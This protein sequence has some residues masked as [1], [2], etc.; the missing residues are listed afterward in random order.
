PTIMFLGFKLVEAFGIR[1]ILARAV[2]AG[3]FT[4]LVDA[5]Y[6]L[7]GPLPGVRWWEWLDWTIG[8]RHMFRYWYGWPM[9]EAIWQMTWPPL[10]MWL[11]W[12]WE[13]RRAATPADIAA[14]R[15]APWV[16]LLGVPVLIGLLVNTGGMLLSFPIGIA[17]GL[18]LPHYPFVLAVAVLVCVVFLFAD[19]RPVGLD[20]AGWTLLGIHVVGYGIITAANFAA[21]PVPAGQI[22]IVTLALTALVVL[23]CYARYAARRVPDDA[24]AESR[25]SSRV[26]R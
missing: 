21:R 24:R 16:T 12:Q 1:S 7:T 5:P 8:G 15:R 17:I 11:V 26:V 6:G 22:V 20:R 3:V 25:P 10:L 23:A 18:D 19:K 2:S 13:R 9:A 14:A 4:V